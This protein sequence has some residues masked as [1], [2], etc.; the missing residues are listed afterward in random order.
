MVWHVYALWRGNSKLAQQLID[1][2]LFNKTPGDPWAMLQKQNLSE[3]VV[4]MMMPN[5]GRKSWLFLSKH[6]QQEA[7]NEPG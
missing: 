5:Y 2:R 1:D 4:T 3:I 6:D 7:R